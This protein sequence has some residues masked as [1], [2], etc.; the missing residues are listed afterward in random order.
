MDELLGNYVICDN[1]YQRIAEVQVG[2]RF[3]GGDFHEFLITSRNSTLI[4]LYHA[5]K[6]DLTPIGG[7]RYGSAIDGIIQEIDAL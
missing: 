6:W 2:N 4:I 3:A 7:S 1:S 5:S